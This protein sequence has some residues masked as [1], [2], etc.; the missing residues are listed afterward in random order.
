ML[1][2]FLI[3]LNSRSLAHL[4]HLPVISISLL[5]I[6]I[7]FLIKHRFSLSAFLL[8]QFS[9]RFSL[10]SHLRFLCHTSFSLN[11]D[12]RHFLVHTAYKYHGGC[13][14]FFSYGSAFHWREFLD[15]E[16]LDDIDFWQS[17]FTYYR[18]RH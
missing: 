8:R 18:R 13:K 9:Y 16:I 15:L 5:I 14:R 3:F 4:H 1:H 10:K 17:R 11:L 7:S 6:S 12:T 2:Q